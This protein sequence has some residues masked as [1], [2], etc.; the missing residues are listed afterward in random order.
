MLRFLL[1]ALPPL[2]AAA[3]GA[4]RPAGRT[5]WLLWWDGWAHAPWL[6]Q[7]VAASWEAHNPGWAVQRLDARDVTRLLHVPY[8]EDLRYAQERTARG[9]RK[10]T[11]SWLRA[12][13]S[14]VVR[15]HLLSRFGGVWADATLLCTAPLDTWV[16]EAVAP[17][18]FWAYRAG[19]AN[20]ESHACSW[21]LVATRRA[22]LMQLWRDAT[23]A[24]WH[25]RLSSP[26]TPSLGYFWLDEL[27][28][29]LVGQPG[30]D[31][32][33][34]WAAVPVL[35]CDSADGPHMLGYTSHLPMTGP[36]RQALRAHP[37]RA[38]KLSRHKLRDRQPGLWGWLGK[39]TP[40]AQSSAAEA[41]A[42]SASA[43]LQARMHNGSHAFASS[44]YGLPALLLRD[45]ATAM[46]AL[47]KVA[48]V[49]DACNFCASVPRGVR[50][51]PVPPWTE[52]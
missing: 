50:C 29:Q 25:S 33:R 9:W 44:Q 17:A 24:Y 8:L 2:L 1:L 10:P 7:Q 4:L 36:Q 19:H 32:A 6:A 43:A 52:V 51:V 5:V 23:D 37:P 11:A 28:L 49:R 16:H 46:L 20:G 15:V 14:D 40:V 21:F 26:R 38:L 48:A 47:H 12:A 3:A 45:C 27:F 34:E 39:R 41:I 18:G 42:L 31:A 22:R 35:D 13:Q 30:S